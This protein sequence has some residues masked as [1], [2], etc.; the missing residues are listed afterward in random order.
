[1]RSQPKPLD[2]T[3]KVTFEYDSEDEP[4][5][6]QQGA[7][8]FLVANERWIRDAILARVLAA[9]PENKRAYEEAVRG[10]DWPS[11]PEIS[12]VDGLREVIGPPRIIVHEGEREFMAS[13]GFVFECAWDPEHGLG[14]IVHKL[15]VIEIGDKSRA[16]EGPFGE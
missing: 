9:Y 3:V 4:T 7:T 1:M 10:M 13:L 5:R 14:V 6:E 16:F 12:S 8:T 2:G 15:D 11:L